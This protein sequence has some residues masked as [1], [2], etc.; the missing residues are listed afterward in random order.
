[1]RQIYVIFYGDG[2]TEIRIMIVIATM[3]EVLI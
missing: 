2:R 1:M 3:R